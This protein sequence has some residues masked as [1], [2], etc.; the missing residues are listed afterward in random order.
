MRMR[1]GQIGVVAALGQARKLRPAGIG[2]PQDARGL[3]KRLARRVVHGLAQQGIVAVVVDAHQVAVAAADHQAHKGRFQI[4]GGQKVGAHVALDV[5]DRNQRPLRGI[6]QPLHAADAREQRAHQPWPVGDGQGVHVLQGHPRLLERLIHH[7]V[8]GVHVRAAGDFRN[9]AAI[10]RVQIHL[11][12]NHIAQNAA[13]VFHHGRRGF[14]AAG[15]QGQDAKGS[16]VLQG[17]Q[18]CL[19]VMLRLHEIVPP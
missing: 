19:P 6:A 2:Q 4:L 3:V 17:F 14:V 15:L 8:A 18:H 5:V 16:L 9:D 11:R 12:K 13:A 10:E 1:Q 7:P